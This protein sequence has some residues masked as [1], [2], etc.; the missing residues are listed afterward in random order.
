MS[1]KLS[2]NLTFDVHDEWGLSSETE[3]AI[4]E[5]IGR[6]TAG[7]SGKALFRGL[8]LDRHRDRDGLPNS[9]NLNFGSIRLRLYDPEEH[10][11]LKMTSPRDPD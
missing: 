10:G 1:L 6:S 11:E 9:F 2:V 8:D 5:A 7:E 3:T 4:S